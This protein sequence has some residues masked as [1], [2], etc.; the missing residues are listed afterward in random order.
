MVF[1]VLCLTLDKKEDGTI[2]ADGSELTAKEQKMY[3]LLAVF[4]GLVLAPTCWTIKSYYARQ[5]IENNN[6]FPMYDLGIDQMI[7]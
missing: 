7:F 6:E 3:G 4:F 2:A 5:A 1:C